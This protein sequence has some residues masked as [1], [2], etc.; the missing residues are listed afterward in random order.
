MPLEA[1]P[2]TLS[3]NDTL[4]GIWAVPVVEPSAPA[5]DVMV[6]TGGV[7]SSTVIALS[8]EAAISLLFRSETAPASMVYPDAVVVPVGVL[9][10]GRRAAADGNGPVGARRYGRVG[11]GAASRQRPPYPGCPAHRMPLEA[12]P[13][14]L[15]SNDT[16]NAGRC[17]SWS[18]RA[19]SRR[20]GRPESGPAP[21]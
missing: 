5:V 18:R 17:P 2:V 3:S 14:T 19:R 6:G 8:G 10:D 12:N 4:N 16:L 15:S 9:R 20:D 13:V 21:S 7:V 11:A 1:N